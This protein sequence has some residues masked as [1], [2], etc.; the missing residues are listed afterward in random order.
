MFKKVITA[1]LIIVS[2]LT[3][4]N[5]YPIVLCT[6]LLVGGLKKWL[7]ISIGVVFGILR[8]ILKEQGFNVI[9]VSIGPVSSNW[10]R[11]VEI[12]YQLKGGQVNYGKKSC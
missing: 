11:A 7:A 1:L 2:V 12:Y 5:K 8:N 3:S 10:E 6:V 9:T 4:Q